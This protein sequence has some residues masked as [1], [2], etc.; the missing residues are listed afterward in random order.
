VSRLYEYRRFEV[1]PRTWPDVSARIGA[2]GRRAVERAGGRLFGV[3][4]GQIGIGSN[5]G[6][7][8]TVWPDEETHAKQAGALL[9]A[10]GEIGN[11][12]TERLVLRAR[13]GNPEPPTAEGIYAHRWFELLAEDR[14]EFVEL[15]EAAW[16]DFEG[17]HDAN[18]VGL[19]ETLDPEPPLTRLLLLT[20]YGSLTVWE[21]SR[22]AHTDQE[23]E[24]WERFL[25]R[26]QLTRSTIVAIARLARA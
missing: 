16:P 25:R 21:R 12:S 19:W 14:P 1:P 13:A 24:A 26:H 3:F 4:T 9:E 18:I 5:E 11:T 6:I 2:A 8:M 22:S 15:S 7:V 23:R 10:A 17:S 20:R